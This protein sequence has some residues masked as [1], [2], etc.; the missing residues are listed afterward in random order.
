M[1]NHRYSLA[2]GPR[3]IPNRVTEEELMDLK[4][5]LQYSRSWQ[6]LSIVFVNAATCSALTGDMAQAEVFEACAR[7]DVERLESMINDQAYNAPEIVGEEHVEP[8]TWI[9]PHVGSHGK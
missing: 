7:F 1:S 2:P 6:I 4:R 5:M 8:S 9:D 3:M